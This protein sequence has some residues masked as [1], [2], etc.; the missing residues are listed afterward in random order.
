MA[1]TSTIWQPTSRMYA[2]CEF[3]GGSYS[4]GQHNLFAPVASF[5]PFLSGAE[6]NPVIGGGVYFNN[7]DHPPPWG[8]NSTVRGIAWVGQRKKCYVVKQT[9]DSNPNQD[10]WVCDEMFCDGSVLQTQWN[11]GPASGGSAYDLFN[12]VPFRHPDGDGLATY[13]ADLSDSA[14]SWRVDYFDFTGTRYTTLTNVSATL[15]ARFTANGEAHDIA[16]MCCGDG[17]SGMGVFAVRLVSTF[18]SSVRTQ[19]KYQLVALR[20]GTQILA[21]TSYH[22]FD[23][24]QQEFYGQPTF[25]PVNRRILMPVVEYD[26]DSSND[27]I[28]PTSA[29]IEAFTLID[30]GQAWTAANVTRTTLITLAL[31]TFVP[32]PDFPDIL[33]PQ[34]TPQVAWFNDQD[35]KIYV[36]L[37]PNDQTL[38]LGDVVGIM[39]YN[40]DGSTPTQIIYDGFNAD[41][42]GDNRAG[43]YS[44]SKAV[45]FGPGCM[46]PWQL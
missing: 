28:E 35:D 25:D 16:H 7:T 27:S 36:M 44:V 38:G 1:A 26:Y 40:S 30:P 14:V 2:A 4:Y 39:R 41:R 18:S 9:T 46:A 42:W 31:D 15:G 12:M 20:S 29:T 17:E 33:A 19:A 32:Q 24:A 45:A 34:T 10:L 21:T 37:Q 3:G 5:R 23:A 43:Y 11:T 13:S 22:T 6:D 8:S